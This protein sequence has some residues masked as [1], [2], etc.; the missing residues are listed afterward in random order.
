MP[1]ARE[2]NNQNGGKQHPIPQNVLG[3]EFKLV[4]GLTLRQFG[5]LAFFV[6]I[7]FIIYQSGLPGII[8]VPVASTVAIFGA[9]ISLVPIQDRSADIWIKN[10]LFAI[11]SPTERVWQKSEANLDLFFELQEARTSIRESKEVGPSHNRTELKEFLRKSENDEKTVLDLHEDEFLRSVNLLEEEIAIPQSLAGQEIITD[12]GRRNQNLPEEQTFKPREE[13]ILT[14][15]LAS[16]VNYSEE[17]IISLPTIAGRR[18]KFITPI[19]NTRAGRPLKRPRP[20]DLGAMV[21]GEKVVAAPEKMVEKAQ[22]LI[23]RFKEISQKIDVA[24]KITSRPAEYK[25]EPAEPRLIQTQPGRLPPNETFVQTEGPTGV[26]ESLETPSQE[27]PEPQV[28]NPQ[29]KR[30]SWISNFMP[31]SQS[32]KEVNRVDVLSEELA[33]IKAEKEKLMQDL[34]GQKKA[35]LEA[36]TLGSMATEYQKRASEVG[37]QNLR[38]TQEFK[39]A[40][41]ELKK[42]QEYASSTT[43]QKELLARQAKEI[44]KRMDELLREKTQTSDNL[45]NLQKELR[46]LRIKQR[47]TIPT[48]PQDQPKTPPTSTSPAYAGPSANLPSFV[49][50]I[51]VINGYVKGKTGNLL[52]DAVVIVKDLAGSPVRALKTNEL[53]QFAITTPVPNGSYTVEVSSSG[54]TFAIMT[55]EVVGDILPPLEFVGK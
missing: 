55:V 7:A 44:Q 36:E 53:G 40:Q 16:E 47:F 1:Q 28:V 48:P 5:F 31:K 12:A 54:E 24:Q 27:T 3:V 8:K 17:K 2:N 15:N 11:S 46:E 29:E 14:H 50:E 51:N 45:I 42:L 6:V 49:K 34:E 18:P 39:K 20:E 23:N 32:P 10:F 35:R 22:T 4:G 37:Q 13:V 21:S 38:L 43:S 9:F 26:T 33:K 41:E 52:K 30:A 25:A 19:Q